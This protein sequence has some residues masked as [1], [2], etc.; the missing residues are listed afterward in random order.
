MDRKK[1]IADIKQEFMLKRIRAQEKVDDFI[2]HLKKDPEFD[3]LYTQ[4]SKKSLEYWRESYDEDNIVLKHDV[5][6][7]KL[8]IDKYLT[9]KNIDKSLLTPKYDCPIC[10]DTGV[11]GGRVCSCL[12]SKLNS[13][14]SKK[15]SSST[16]FKSFNNCNLNIMDDVDKKAMEKLKDW[17]ESYPNVKKKNIN[18]LG[19]SGSGKTFLLECIAG[20][21]IKKDCIICFKTAFE[22]NELARLYHIGKSY[23]FMDCI[24]SEVLLI[25]DLGT[26]PML[27]NVTKE[28]LYNLINTRQNKNLAT[29][30]STNLS[31]E[32]LLSRYD[33][34]IFSRLVNKN[35]S[36][37]ISLT[38]KDKRI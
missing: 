8:K 18:I 21:L 13:E 31:L 20:S 36:L 11:V 19:V 4:Y 35:L 16:N 28:Y 9:D 10:N 34:R 5:E 33:E 38:S 7:L 23:D 2:E 32:D 3:D 22:L 27:N 6:D 12:L 37:T 26:E 25:D 29:I 15:C 30:I 24:N 17:C 14:I 1:L